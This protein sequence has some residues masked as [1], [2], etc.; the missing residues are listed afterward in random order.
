MFA[1]ICIP[2]FALQA[3]LRLE[4]EVYLQP[5]ALMGFDA[6]KPLIFEL[7][8][9]AR[10]LGVAEGMTAPQ[11]VARCPG[12]LFRPRNA[13]LEATASE[14]LLQCAW[15]FSP[16]IEATAPG[17]VTL[18]LRGLSDAGNEP[19]GMRIVRALEQLSL[20]GQ[21]GAAANPGLALL[22]AQ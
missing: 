5:A 13:A 4:P 15:L 9:A 6:R 10:Q 12:I 16:A 7:T 17:V 20:R 21:A 8:P 2:D 11:A 3:V 1:V 14:L 22:A 18:D 19:W